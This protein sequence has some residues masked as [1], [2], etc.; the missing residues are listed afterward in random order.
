[1]CL[2]TGLFRQACLF[3]FFGNGTAQRSGEPNSSIHIAK[4]MK[5]PLEYSPVA[6]ET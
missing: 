1:M 2:E 5:P 4:Q 6:N 3:L